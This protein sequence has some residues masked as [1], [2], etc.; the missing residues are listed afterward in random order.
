MITRMTGVLTRVLDDEARLSVGPFE[1]QVLLP[2]VVRQQLMFR[3]GEEV[4]LHILEYMEGNQSGNR[5]VPRKVGFMR[6]SELEFFE[7][8][9]TVD[10]IGAKKALKAM[11]RPVREMADAIQRQDTAWLSSLPGIGSSSAEQIANALKKKV[12]PFLTRADDQPATTSA[13]SESTSPQAETVP[14]KKT[15]KARKPETPPREQLDPALLSDV[16]SALIAT[17][18]TPIEARSKIDLLISSGQPV[19]SHDEALALIFSR[20]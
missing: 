15:A 16:Y 2:D 3:T 6:E 19:R 18:L 4:T 8:F 20:G 14:A 17:G 11:A 7:L 9:C 12:L 13:I 1:Y 10:R 5:F